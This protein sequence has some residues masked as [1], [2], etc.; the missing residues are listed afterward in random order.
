VHEPTVS[1][2]GTLTCNFGDMA[3]GTSKSV[4]RRHTGAT[5]AGARAILPDRRA[6]SAGFSGAVRIQPTFV[7]HGADGGEGPDRQHQDR[8]TTTQTLDGDMNAPLGD[9]ANQE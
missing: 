5:G 8:E 3:E 9:C 1:G 2:D 6:R 4:T 7:D